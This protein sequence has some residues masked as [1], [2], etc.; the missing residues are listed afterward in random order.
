MTVARMEEV[1]KR[2]VSSKID[3]SPALWADLQDTFHQKTVEK[4]EYLLRRGEICRH[5]YFIV[6]G[7]FM[8]VH[9]NEEGKEFVIAFHVDEVYRYITSHQ[10]YFTAQP[11][12]N[13]IIALEDS[14]VLVFQKIGIERLSEEYSEFHRY[15]YDVTAQGLLFLNLFSTMRLSTSH[16]KFLEKI[17]LDYPVFLRRIPDKY[18]A[19][20]MGISVEWFCKLKKKFLK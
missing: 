17:Y 3:L 18:I 1:F 4:G 7:S 15:Y 13:A 16:A 2:D 10:S 14:E 9:I 19:E 6:K 11:S 5:G 12:E 20:F 8:H